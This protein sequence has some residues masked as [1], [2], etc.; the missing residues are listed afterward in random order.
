MRFQLLTEI[1]LSKLSSTNIFGFTSYFK[2]H[3]QTARLGIYDR[4]FS[5][6]KL[7]Q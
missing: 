4:P 6:L 5:S 2:R 3:S 1:F 7:L